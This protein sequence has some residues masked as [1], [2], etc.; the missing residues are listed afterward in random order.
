MVQN[1]QEI[2]QDDFTGG[3]NDRLTMDK[4]AENQCVSIKNLIPS[5]LGRSLD[6]RGG[7]AATSIGIAASRDDVLG[8][9]GKKLT[10]GV[11][12]TIVAYI[13]GAIGHKVLSLEVVYMN[14]SVLSKTQ[15]DCTAVTLNSSRE[16]ATSL[17]AVWF[18]DW[19][20]DRFFFSDDFSGLY[21]VKL[22]PATLGVSA[23]ASK[24][25]NKNGVSNTV[26]GTEKQLVAAPAGRH[27]LQH[28]GRLWLASGS[29]VYFCGTD[30][31]QTNQARWEN[32]L[33]YNGVDPAQTNIDD[34]NSMIMM[35]FGKKVTALASTYNG[36]MVFKENSIS[37]WSYP[38][39]A[40]PWEVGQGAAI[41]QLAFSVGCVDS[42]CM[43]AK[44]DAILF[45]GRNTTGDLGLYTLSG[46]EV[47]QMNA[48]IPQRL[49]KASASYVLKGFCLGDFF[50]VVTDVGIALAYSLIHDSWFDIESPVVDCPSVS[51]DV[52]RFVGDGG[53]MY[54]YPSG[55]TD[56][57]A[58]VRFDI[59]TAE[60]RPKGDYGTF[61]SRQLFFEIGSVNPVS[62]SYSIVYNGVRVTHRAK[63]VYNSSLNYG[64]NVPYGVKYDLLEST[65]DNDTSAVKYGDGTKYGAKV[66]VYGGTVGMYKMMK[67]ALNARAQ[68]AMIEIRG[69][70]TTVAFVNKVGWGYRGRTGK[71]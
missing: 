13:S 44:G 9:F 17:E 39:G 3:V 21:T 71:T 27:L 41:E 2:W 30:D 36:L 31:T 63:N 40:A 43:G 49:A 38:D 15:I 47:A 32:W 24:V 23:V 28:K 67:T 25:M 14:G 18:C 58:P 11:E 56:G 48:D 29:T 51:G 34:G 59:V 8:T 35:P 66:A 50:Y 61:H 64:D 54:E 55:H 57:A 45:L 12:V 5:K 16:F 22:N 20:S 1:L 65:F 70:A 7:V 10:N 68:T 60:L 19:E 6:V 42:S 26:G 52:A 62:V 33:P 53:Y 4:L 37:M 46:S 69:E